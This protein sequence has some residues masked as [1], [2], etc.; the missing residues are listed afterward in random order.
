MPDGRY[1]ICEWENNKPKDKCFIKHP[2]GG[3][4]QGQVEMD[5]LK[6]HGEGLLR[7]SNGEYFSGSW[8]HGEFVNGK[9][10]KEEANI[11]YEGDW[12]KVKK[13]SI[14]NFGGYLYRHFWLKML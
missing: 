11:T 10:R 9:V 6:Y 2:N 14:I 1:V 7:Y 5:D 3:K 12:C 8:E 4:Y 13:S